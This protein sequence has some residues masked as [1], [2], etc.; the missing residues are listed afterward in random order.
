MS[1]K[2]SL[3]K[4]SAEDLARLVVEKRE[5]LRALRFAVAGSKNRNVK[6][7]STLRKQIA[8]ALTELN[9]RLKV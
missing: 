6:Q 8:R 1:K 9:S 3:T 7:A 5:E 4:H 2:N